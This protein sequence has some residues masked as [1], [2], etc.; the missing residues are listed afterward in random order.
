VAS[1][2]TL[3]DTVRDVVDEGRHLPIP[4]GENEVRVEADDS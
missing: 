1:E 2:P 4:I 3:G